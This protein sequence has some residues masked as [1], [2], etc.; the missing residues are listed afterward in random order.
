MRGMQL[1]R[2]L[3]EMRCYATRGAEHNVSL[4][5]LENWVRHVARYKNI[6]PVSGVC[7][8]LHTYTVYSSRYLPT[9]RALVAIQRPLSAL[10]L[11]FPS[12]RRV[13]WGL[14]W[15][16]N[17]KAILQGFIVLSTAGKRFAEV[18]DSASVPHTPAKRVT[19]IVL[20]AVLAFLIRI[21][22]DGV[23]IEISLSRLVGTPYVCRESLC[24]S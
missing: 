14:Y 15:K 17:L 16:A 23:S 21:V 19:G 9:N 3:E 12:L 10:P 22:R 24:P 20:F 4:A 1:P 2:D 7:N 11:R 8:T 18:A 6:R 5:K 13:S